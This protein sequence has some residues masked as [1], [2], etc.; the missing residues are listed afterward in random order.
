MAVFTSL[1]AGGQAFLPQL[2]TTDSPA[3]PLSIS[4]SICGLPPKNT[5]RFSRCSSLRKASLL[6]PKVSVSGVSGSSA[7]GVDQRPRDEIRGLIYEGKVEGFVKGG[8][9]IRFNSLVGFLP[10]SELS[11]SHQCKEPNKNIQEIASGLVGCILPVKAIQVSEELGKLIFS[12]KEA[13]WAK[14]SSQIKIGAIFEGRVRFVEDFGALVGLRFPD[15]FYHLAGFVH[16]SEVSWDTIHDARDVLTKGDVVRVKVIK[17]D[18]EKSRISLS[19]K[20]LEDDPLL[21]TLDKVIPQDS[22][23]YPSTLSPKDS[24]HIEPL[25]GIGT[26]I[27]ELMQEDGNHKLEKNSLCLP[28]LEDRCKKYSLRRP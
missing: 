28:G 14:F 20:Q 19:I 17:L 2:S 22:S 9:R 26:I 3:A 25:P 4:Q 16:A 18:S 1:L 5:H 10:F 23:L 6:A 8:L 15:G 13:M 27:E 21:E 11:P 7:D 24:V 12:E